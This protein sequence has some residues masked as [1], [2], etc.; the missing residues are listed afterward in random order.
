MY[1][2]L[3]RLYLRHGPASQSF[4]RF[5]CMSVIEQWAHERPDYEYAHIYLRDGLRCTNPVCSRRDVTPHHIC[6]RSH[7]GGDEAINLTSPCVWCHLQGVH[8]G[9]LEVTGHAPVLKWRIAGH[10]VVDGRTR[11]RAA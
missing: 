1:R 5:A 7:G 8:E 11:R 4:L 2:G 9:R 10:T 3:E 6:F